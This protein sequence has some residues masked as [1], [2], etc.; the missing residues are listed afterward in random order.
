MTLIYKATIACLIFAT[1]LCSCSPAVNTGLIPATNLKRLGIKE[2]NIDRLDSLLGSALINQWAAEAAALVAKNG[3]IVFNKNFGFRDRETK[4]LSRG[5]DEFR[6][7]AL[8]Q[9]IVSLAALL[10][11]EKGKL[12][13]D[14]K[15]AKYIP[16]FSKPEIINSFNQ[17]DT[18][19]TTKPALSDITIRQLLNHTSG[20]AGAGNGAMAMLYEKNNIPLFAT[21]ENFSLNAKMKTLATLPLAYQPSTQYSNGLSADVLGA[22]IE[23]ASGLTLDSVVSQ[24]I[25][26]PLGMANTCFFLPLGK[27]NRLSTMYSEL[28]NGRLQRSPIVQKQFDLN[29]PIAGGKS[30]LSGAS[31]LVSTADDYAKFLQMILNKGLFNNKQI[32]KAQTVALITE[33]Q[34]GDLMAA[35]HKYSFGFDL[36]MNAQASTRAMPG[37]LSRKGE[38]NTYCWVDAQRGTIA[39]LFTQVYPSINGQKLRDDFERIVNEIIDAAKK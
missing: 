5:I 2:K 26:R 13:L 21:T 30:Y 12:N 39:L 11:V 37:K 6:L 4:A 28:P 10:L 25:L 24:S 31:G 17:N 9:P 14:D 36:E 32:A 29:Y 18:S 15:V 23:K 1:A 33:N 3:E 38:F 35:E 7:G 22:V 8:T 27:A 34:I 16:E 19:F 20:I